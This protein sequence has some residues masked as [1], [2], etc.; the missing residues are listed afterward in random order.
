MAHI[1]NIPTE[2][3]LTRQ[4]EWKNAMYQHAM[5]MLH[6]YIVFTKKIQF[7]FWLL[8][9]SNCFGNREIC[10]AQCI[11]RQVSNMNIILHWNISESCGWKMFCNKVKYAYE[12]I[13][14]SFM[15]LTSKTGHFSILLYL[16]I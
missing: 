14:T 11:V 1:P 8:Q 5:I 16:D 12:K 6:I 9:V 7:H 4:P 3:S 10:D 15:F 2:N 13:D